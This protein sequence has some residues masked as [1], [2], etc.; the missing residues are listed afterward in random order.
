LRLDVV[1]GQKLGQAIAA[2]ERQH[3]I[4]HVER[5]GAAFDR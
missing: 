2:V 3:R 1:V 5:F 4:Q